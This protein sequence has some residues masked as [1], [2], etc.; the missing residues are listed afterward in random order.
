MT[1][2]VLKNER[3]P[4]RLGHRLAPTEKESKKLTPFFDAISQE[5]VQFRNVVYL[6][7]RFVEIVAHPFEVDDIVV[8]DN[9]GS[10]IVAIARLADRT[11]IDQGFFITQFISVVDL[12]GK[13]LVQTFG[14]HA[15]DVSVPLKAVIPHQAENAF[16]LALVEDIFRKDVFIQGVAG[17]AVDKHQ[18]LFTADAGK[19][20]Q[21]FP[22]AFVFGR[23]ACFQLLS[24]PENGPFRSGVESFRIEQ[25]CLVVISKNGDFSVVDHQINT[26]PRIG[27]VP[28]DI[29]QTVDLFDPLR[30]N[31]LQDRLQGFQVS[32]DVAD[33]G[34]QGIV[35]VT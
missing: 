1:R 5:V 2:G 31:I 24:C 16:H 19:L 7:G 30:P 12:L 26:F 13:E 22:P 21:K 20:P 32:M 18:F 33:N 25:G 11:D 14:E 29:T 17:R 8:Q 3:A 9:V 23:V 4:E 6:L 27:A 10:P 28:D 35:P 34:S 15:R